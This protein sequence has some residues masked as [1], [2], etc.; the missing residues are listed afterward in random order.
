MIHELRVYTC[1]P[2]KLPAFLK[3]IEEVG[4]P[5]RGDKYGRNVGYWT[6]EFG[7]LN[8][9]YHMWEYDDLAHRA[10]M[11]AEL[12]KVEAWR[13][14]YVA[15]AHGFIQRQDVKFLQ[16]QAPLK[17]PSGTGHIYELRQYQIQTGHAAEWLGHFKDIMPVREKYSPNVCFWGSEVPLPN[18]VLHMWVYDS[19]NQRFETR[20]K[21]DQDKDWQG[22]RGKAGHLLQNMNSII[23]MPTVF[24]PMR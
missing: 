17:A 16:P 9:V 5:I 22:F 15:N 14:D 6:S 24:S 10:A 13:K 23:L 19:L 1:F 12:G 18:N 20:V 7:E 11:R 3:L 21:V 8:Q 4:R 2:G